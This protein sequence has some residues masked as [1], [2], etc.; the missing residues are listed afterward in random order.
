MTTLIELKPFRQPW[1][2][3]ELMHES[4]SAELCIINGGQW[5]Q[6]EHPKGG[7]L[8]CIKNRTGVDAIRIARKGDKWYWEIA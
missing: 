1:L 3:K 6:L 5:A 4:P 7:P 2:S 8:G